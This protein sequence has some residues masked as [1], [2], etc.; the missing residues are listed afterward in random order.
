MADN[1]IANPGSGGDTFAADDV[2]GV[3]VPYSKIDL[4]GDGVSSPLSTANPMPS[5]PDGTL[6]GLTGDKAHVFTPDSTA[7]DT[8]TTVG[9]SVEF[10]CEG[11]STASLVLTG[12]QTGL[13]NYEVYVS[14]EGDYWAY[15]NIFDGLGFPYGVI[16]DQAS[17]DNLTQVA[18][19]EIPHIFGV[20]G[21]QFVQVKRA[22]GGTDNSPVT[23]TIRLNSQ[24][25]SVVTLSGVAK[26]EAN[27]A[28]PVTGPLTDAELRASEVPVSGPVTDAQLR[29]TPVPVFDD[30]NGGLLQRILFMLMA[31]LGYDKS[32]QR[33][34]GTVILES[35]TVTTVSTVSTVS[36]VTAVSN[37]NG[38]NGRNAD[39]DLNAN[40]N[41]A[42]A[43]NVRSRIT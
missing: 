33:Q 13:R 10:N 21:F 14:Q 30:A 40:V 22:S 20:T 25:G 26:I 7:S 43:L 28:I 4:G 18:G 3:K 5:K 17:D 19:F 34:R 24:A 11:Y 31:P 38:I 37:L 36:T 42:W 35:G 27:A 6:W 12:T 32:L 15:V 39:M 29:A 23:V 9:T 41:T 1:F 8:L 2:A 16:K